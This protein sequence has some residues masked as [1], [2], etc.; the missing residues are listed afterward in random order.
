MKPI[1]PPTAVAPSRFAE[2][3]RDADEAARRAGVSVAETES[4]PE[5]REISSMLEAVWGRG[6]EG[7]PIGSELM[8]SLAHAGGAVT[9][10]RAADGTLAG[11]AVLTPAAPAG[12]TYSLIAAAAPGA[13]DRGV[14]RALKLRQ[15]AW[16]LG[17]GHRVMR[18]TFDPLVGRNARFNL[19]RLGAEAGEYAVSFYGRMID[20]IN[21]ADESDRLVAHWQLDGDRAAAAAAGTQPPPPPPTADA[22]VLAD[23][24]DGRSMAL[25]DVSGLWFRVPQDIVELRRSDPEQATSWRGALRETLGQ[26]IVTG[27]VAVH[28]TRDGWYLVVEAS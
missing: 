21:G 14:G 28:L 27:G 23:G 3:A 16:A 17:Q 13:A 11:A 10:A 2:A 18:W 25:R 9:V 24:P 4:M 22:E 19:V 7:V 26:A 1:A 8:R 6:P 20:D 5:L 12:A 15:R